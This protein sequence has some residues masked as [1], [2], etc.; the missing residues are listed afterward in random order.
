M[1]D[2]QQPVR[3]S[4]YLFQR[5]RNALWRLRADAGMVSES[6]I[7]RTIIRKTSPATVDAMERHFA[8]PAEARGTVGRFTRPSLLL[9]AT[10]LAQLDRLAESAKAPSRSAAARF[11]ILNAGAHQ[12]PLTDAV[13]SEIAI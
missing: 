11:L 7:L 1:S 13:A 8:G 12:C 5:D 9:D 4:L 6:R 3:V 10:D 2:L